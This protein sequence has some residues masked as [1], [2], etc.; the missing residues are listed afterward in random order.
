MAEAKLL[1]KIEGMHCDHC[2][3]SVENAVKAVPGVARVAVDLS[4]GAA[5]VVYEPGVAGPEAIKKAVRDAGYAV[6]E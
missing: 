2:Q 6:K 3:R 4:G 1:L 5:E